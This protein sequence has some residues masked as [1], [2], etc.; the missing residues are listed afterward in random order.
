MHHLQQKKNDK[1]VWTGRPAAVTPLISTWTSQMS[2]SVLKLV[3]TVD[4]VALSEPGSSV[5]SEDRAAIQGP[6]GYLR[7]GR[8]S[9][10]RTAIWG[11]DGLWGPGSSVKNG[12]LSGSVWNLHEAQDWR[13]ELTLCSWEG[14]YDEHVRQQGSLLE[15]VSWLPSEVILLGVSWPV[16]LQHKSIFIQGWRRTQQ[17]CFKKSPQTSKHPTAEK[18]ASLCLILFLTEVKTESVFFTPV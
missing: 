10:D 15:P 2:H 13:R 6:D 18:L 16:E 8:L 7:T 5:L 14:S 3:R 4:Q 9:E 17:I 11:P 12:R 1:S